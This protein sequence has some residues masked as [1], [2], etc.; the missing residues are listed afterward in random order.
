MMKSHRR[1]TTLFE[2]ILVLAIVAVVSAMSVPS[3]QSM[4]G[5]YKLNGAVDSVR[6]AWAE[7]RAQAIEEKRPYRFSV[8]PDGRAFRVA[9]DQDDYWPGEGSPDDPDGR[10]LVLQ[11]A[12]PPGVHFAV[13]GESGAAANDPEDY[14]L[15]EKP[16]HGDN[17]STTAV[18]MP[19]GTA[20]EDV[21]IRF[22]IKG[23]RPIV[24]TLRGLTGDSSVETESH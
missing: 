8:Q 2:L 16:V 17:W 18:F 5:S 24:L 13:N 19:N 6:A 20:G 7:A 1:A 14:S 21:T 23:C 10:G 9:P 4:Y 11:H 3:L 15:E 22:Q 12:L